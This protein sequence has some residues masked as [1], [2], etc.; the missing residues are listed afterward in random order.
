MMQGREEARLEKKGSEK[1]ISHELYEDKVM[2][3]QT[4]SWPRGHHEILHAVSID[5][6]ATSF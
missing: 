4:E 3:P 6:V 2:Q 5:L 1:Q